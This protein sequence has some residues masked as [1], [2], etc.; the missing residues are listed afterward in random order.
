ME[1]ELEKKIKVII[2]GC[3]IMGRK[4]AEALYEK[5]SFEIVGA[6]DINPDLSGLDLGDVFDK[7]YKTGVIIEKDAEALFSKVSAHA[8]VLTTISHLKKVFPQIVQCMK[9]GLNVISTCEEL[10]FPW[11]READLAREIDDLAKDYGVTVV[12]TGINPGYLMDTLPL[13][14]T[15]P[16][17]RVD[18][19]KVTRMMDSSK[20]RIPFQKK[21]GTSMTKEEFREKI[22]NGTITGH[23][24]LLESIN[25]IAAGLGWSLDEAVELPPEPV[26]ADRR[27]ETGLGPVG[28][29]DVVGLLSVAFAKRAGKDVITLEFNAN[30]SVDEE[31]DEIVIEGVPRIHEKI[32]GGI[33][34]D[35]GTVA[36]TINTIPRAVEAP[37]GVKVMKDLPPALATL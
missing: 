23:V 27:I 15:A 6:V 25:M 26:I 14:L 33:H 29:G 22:D 7:P 1:E 34:G 30:A 21:V 8:A 24:G 10:S 36:V 19:I 20:R 4:V 17:L 31:Y 9:A 37:P 32:I 35:I 2:Y 11:K 5:E 16:C 13:V 3:G 28:P 18:S 12:G